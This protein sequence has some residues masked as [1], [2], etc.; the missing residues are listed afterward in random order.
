[1]SVAEQ[2]GSTGSGAVAAKPPAQKIQRGTVL[3]ASGIALFVLLLFFVLPSLTSN[4]WLQ[5][6]TQVI[7]YSVVA[8]GLAIL[9][10]RVGMVSLGQIALLALGGWIG[11]RLGFATGLPFPILMLAAGILTGGLGVIVGLPALR[12]SGLYLALITLM[13]AAAISIV[14]QQTNF[15][16]GGSGFLGYSITGSGTAALRRPDIASTT[17]SFFRYTLVVGGLMFL[18][19]WFHV[20]GKPGRAWA[21]IRQSQPAALAGGVNITLYKLW[22]FALAAF[23]TGVMGCLLAA[24]GGG[25]TILQFPTQE[26]I[27]LLAAVFMGGVY[28]FS[29][30]IVAGVFT[31]LFPALLDNWDLPPDL[32]LILFGVGVLQVLLTAPRGLAVQVPKDLAKLARLIARPFTRGKSAKEAAR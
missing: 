10:G 29:G 7:V 19:A 8:L 3:H 11:L 32:L 1:M 25:L 26:S 28:G 30:A 24:S 14:L 13:A 9:V 16:N 2:T 5:I 21:A 12:L 20:R 17:E 15:P 4:Y 22:A 31:K 18:L 23:M 27:S 6:C